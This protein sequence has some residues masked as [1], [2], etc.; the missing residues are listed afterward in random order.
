MTDRLEDEVKAIIAEILEIKESDLSAHFAANENA[1]Q[2][3]SVAMLEI[4]VVLERRFQITIQEDE[5]KS[6][7]GWPSL[8]ELIRS[9]TSA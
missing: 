9:K 1:I 2:I 6:I 3:D 4:V 5:M 8:I 7:T